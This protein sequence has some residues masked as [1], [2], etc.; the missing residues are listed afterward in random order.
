VTPRAVALAIGAGVAA[1]ASVVVW[2]TDR[3]GGGTDAASVTTAAAPALDGASLFQAK[4]CASCHTG[5]DSASLFSSFPNLADV[6]SWAGERVPGMSAAD[7]VTQ[8]I[9]DP[10]AVISPQF[11]PDGGP[12]TGMPALALSD[13]EVAALV[14]YLL[15]S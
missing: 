6:P 15:E 1:V 5:P 7:Y 4:G 12:T 10:L 14:K 9:R 11:T 8:S 3:D 13:A 2:T